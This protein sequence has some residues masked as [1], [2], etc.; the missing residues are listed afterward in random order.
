MKI[1]MQ[2]LLALVMVYSS[3]SVAYV[4]DLNGNVEL[5]YMNISDTEDTSSPFSLFFRLGY[6]V[7]KNFVV[8]GYL[9][10]GLTE[11]DLFYEEFG[12]DSFRT[13]A[14]LDQ[15]YGV[16]A[17]LRKKL[18]YKNEIYFLA[19]YGKTNIEVTDEECFGGF[20]VSCFDDTYSISDEGVSYGAGIDLGGFTMSYNVFYDGTVDDLDVDAKVTG[21]NFGYKAK[22]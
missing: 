15:A 11:D 20:S 7:S 4:G 5:S 22:F 8:Q 3:Q 1:I 17:K 12:F 19:G 2:G 18:S 9:G 16:Q 21:L 6:E 10:T 13:T 14:K